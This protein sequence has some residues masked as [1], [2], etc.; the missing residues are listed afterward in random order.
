MSV[1]DL[2]SWGAWGA[3][4]PGGLGEA[5]PGGGRANGAAQRHRL[6]LVRLNSATVGR[7]V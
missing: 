1:S 7:G 6:D 5:E 3:P 4:V 2:E